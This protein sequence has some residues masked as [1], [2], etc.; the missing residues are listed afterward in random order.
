MYKKPF[1]LIFDSYLEHTLQELGN[2]Y[3]KAA[4]KIHSIEEKDK[5]RNDGE[6]ENSKMG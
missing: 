3:A 1:S 6:W 2:G 5:P 4:M